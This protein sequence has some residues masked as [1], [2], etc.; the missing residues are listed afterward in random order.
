MASSIL[1]LASK[2]L[3]GS[4]GPPL[5]ELYA[6]SAPSIQ[7]ALKQYD[8]AA[9]GIDWVLENWVLT[10]GLTIGV[11]AIGTIGGN[12]LYEYLKRR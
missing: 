8:K 5:S 7:V 10:I 3:V 4:S 11:I 9:P 1:D 12:F 6:Q 2:Y